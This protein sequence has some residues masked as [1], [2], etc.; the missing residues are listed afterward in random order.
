MAKSNLKEKKSKKNS[1]VYGLNNCYYIKTKNY[2]SNKNIL[3]N[4]CEEYKI[5][6]KSAR[7]IIKPIRKHLTK[8]DIIELLNQNQLC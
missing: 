6:Y 7:K 4:I 5:E 1:R 8:N 2:D 3:L